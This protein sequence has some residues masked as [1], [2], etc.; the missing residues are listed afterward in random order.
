M[1]R[2]PQ[3]LKGMRDFLPEQMLLRQHV[4]STFRGV[5]ERYGFEPIETPVIEYLETLTGKYGEDE[6]LIYSFQDRGERNVGLR[7][8]LTVPLARFVANHRNDLTFPFKRYHIAP[9]FRADRPQRGRYREFWQCDADIV[10]T[11]SMMA[12]AEVV[13]VWIDALSAINMPGFVVHIN[14]RKL[15]MSLAEVAGVP[16]DQTPTIHRAID[17]LAKIGEDGVLKEMQSNGIPEDAARRVLDLVSITGEPGEVFDELARRL[18]GNSMAEE[19]ISEM[20]SL[21][22]FLDKMGA[23][24]SHYTLD[25]TLAR[26][27]DYY[28]G[29]VFEA[30]SVDANIGS[31]GGAGRYDGLVGMFSGEDLPATGCSL[32]LERIFDVIQE[33][34]LVAAPS[35]VS[36]VLVTVFNG[37]TIGES[38][39][40]VGELRRAGVESDI[41]SGEKF[42]LR[43]QLQYA[44][45]KG[46]PRTLILGPDEIQTG[47]VIVR[48]MSTGDQQSV[49]RANVAEAIHSALRA[50]RAAD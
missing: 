9:V 4:L 30:M 27:L 1:A 11:K 49:D 36:K 39:A 10:G 31:L 8:D 45:R 32:G 41:Y 16:D 42:D 7:Y 3:V 29:P 21:F 23:D 17:K 33:K 47:Q 26:G 48:E 2:A 24:S 40:L 18:A 20:R 13:S 46:I 22:D 15:L 6:K 43:R 50:D 12:D 44:N 19:G 38:L 25:L 28:T 37:D 34:N 14:H 35:T 5:F